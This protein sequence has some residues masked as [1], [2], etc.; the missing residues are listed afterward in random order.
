VRDEVR[1]FFA[2]KANTTPRTLQL[3]LD[4]IDAC[5]DTRLRLEAPLVDWLNR[6]TK[7]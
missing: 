1:R 2:D 4:R 5:R 3:T 7:R 6:A